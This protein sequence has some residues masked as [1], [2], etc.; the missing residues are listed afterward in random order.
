MSQ[1]TVPNV[2]DLWVLQQTFY[3]SP[4]EIDPDDRADP[5]SVSLTIRDPHGAVLDATAPVVRDSVGLFHYDWTPAIGGPHEITW[6][7]TGAV[8]VVS[9]ETLIVRTGLDQALATTQYIEG[10]LGT[11]GKGN[12]DLVA[13]LAPVCSEHI[14]NHCNRRFLPAGASSTKRFRANPGSRVISLAP[15]DFQ[16]DQTVSVV[17]DAPSGGGQTL[18]LED[19]FYIAPEASPWGIADRI[20]LQMPLIGWRATRIDV[21]AT[22]GWTAIPSPVAE[23]CAFWVR[24][25]IRSVSAY[26]QQAQLEEA[27]SLAADGVMPSQCRQMLKPFK[28]EVLA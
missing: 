9:P 21:T 11:T 26:P 25:L 7:G 19:D 10:V 14:M 27:L 13:R 15:W 28:H 22:W 1:T 2:G 16:D 12:P 5:T 4:A 17:V 3:N 6:H 24:D 8:Q 20:M 23:A 18:V